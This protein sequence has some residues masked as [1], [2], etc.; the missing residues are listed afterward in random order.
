MSQR[1]VRTSLSDTFRA[2]E[3]LEHKIPL[4]RVADLYLI[5]LNAFARIP[6]LFRLH[7]VCSIHALHL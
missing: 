3:A 6:P 2:G 4:C 7:C 1:A 5:P